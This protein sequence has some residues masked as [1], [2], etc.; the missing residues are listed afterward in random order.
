MLQTDPS[1]VT[2]IHLHDL[3]LTYRDLKCWDD[4]I[5]LISVSAILFGVEGGQPSCRS[6]TSL[7][8]FSV[9]I[10]PRWLV[11]TRLRRRS[12]RSST[13]WRL[14]ATVA[15]CATTAA[16]PW[17]SVK[18]WCFLCAGLTVPLRPLIHSSLLPPRT[19]SARICMQMPDSQDAWGL[20]GRI[21][22]D[23]VTHRVSPDTLL[24]PF[25]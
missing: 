20:K 1:F 10:T 17:K 18:S 12:R 22:K 24:C 25:I 6:L 21:Y 4:M 11:A 7:R 2:A 3:L 19:S 13:L 15:T 9:F 8:P 23:Q 16:A 14:P 5:R